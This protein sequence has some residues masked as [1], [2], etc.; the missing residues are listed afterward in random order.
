MKKLLILLSALA[1]STSLYAGSGCGGGGCS[2]DKKSD[3]VEEK[4]EDK[5]SGASCGE[6]KDSDTCT[7]DKG[8]SQA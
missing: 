7:K 5:V 1:L 2:S 3:K 6:K 8:E 4:V